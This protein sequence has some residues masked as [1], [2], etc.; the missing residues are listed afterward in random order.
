MAL[1]VQF[2]Y[3]VN[4]IH[5]LSYVQPCIYPWDETYLNVVIFLIF[6][7][8]WIQFDSYSVFLHQEI[9]QKFSFFVESLCGLDISVSVD[10]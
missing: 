8:S 2:V 9:G 4:Y 5:G 7:Y 10:S 3:M 1:F 6:M